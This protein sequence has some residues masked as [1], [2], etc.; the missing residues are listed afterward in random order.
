MRELKILVAC[1]YS[2]R[3]RD[4]FIKRG[5]DAISCDLLPTDSP[6]PHYQGDVLDI[7]SDGFDLMVAHPNCQFLAVSG[8]RYL[9]NK[10]G[11]KNENRWK[12]RELALNFVLTLMNAPIP[13]IAIENPV[14][15]ISTQIRKPDQIVNPWQF[16]DSFSKKTC[17]WLENL[18]KLVPTNI[19]DPGEIRVFKSG[20][21]M[22]KWMND[23]RGDWK[24]R[25]TTFPGM[26]NAIADQWGNYIANLYV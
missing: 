25:S 5:H 6:G 1:E 8:S 19:V 4:A 16:G 2:G 3:I 14:S 13:H 24:T 23:A 18:P 15:V 11:S 21:R 10:D 22:A 7:I 17:W 26:A 12:N 9:Y 20:N